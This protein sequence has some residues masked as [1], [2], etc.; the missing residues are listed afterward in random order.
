M[1]I[2]E[3]MQTFPECE[4]IKREDMVE[5][6]T[7]AMECAKFY[8]DA[9]DTIRARALELWPRDRNWEWECPEHQAFDAY[10]YGGCGAPN[11][12]RWID[13]VKVEFIAHHGL[14]RT[15]DDAC[16]LAAD[17]WTRMIFS[18][19]TQDNGD[20]TENGAMA[21]MMGTLVKD[22]VASNIPQEVVEKFR[23]QCKTFYLGGCQIETPWGLRR[24]EPYCD[25]QPN[26][27]LCR[28]LSSAGVPDEKVDSICPWKTGIYIDDADN[29][30]VVRGYQKERRI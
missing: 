13:A 3:L 24:S 9:I 26:T 7:K 28:L 29:S 30:V 27:A 17:E 25:Y 16:Q 11:F 21:S 14:V 10:F 19:H 12:R 1:T 22:T 8:Q 4:R 5:C 15:F 2:D 6:V 18:H 23:E 20:N